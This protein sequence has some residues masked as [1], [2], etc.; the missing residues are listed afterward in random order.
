MKRLTL[1]DLG[2]ITVTL[3]LGWIAGFPG[4]AR[5]DC[6]FAANQFTASP[7][8]S[9][10][11][12]PDT[13]SAGRY[14]RPEASPLATTPS[15]YPAPAA[16]G[17]IVGLWKTTVTSQGQVIDQAFDLWNSDGTEILND[18][19]PPQT[20]NVCLGV[21]VKVGSVYKLK[22]PSWIYDSNGN[23]TGTAVISEQ[24][25]VGPDG[26]TYKGIYII[27]FY[28]LNGNHLGQSGGTV[29]ATRIV[30]DF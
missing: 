22:H 10:A 25:T 19:P 27:D 17:S 16:G 7:R 1:R 2:R 23:L 24:V 28:D 18:N 9:V 14:T 30:V 20:G 4:E 6:G 8:L 26:N 12:M 5:A 11:T 13:V 3:V 15:A 21:Y 29:A